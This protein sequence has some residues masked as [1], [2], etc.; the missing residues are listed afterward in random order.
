MKL[1]RFN[2]GRIG[3]V[4]GD[5][6]YDVTTMCGLDP[7][8]WPPVGMVQI[9]A[10]WDRLRPKLEAALKTQQPAALSSVKLQTPNPW[11]NKVMALPANFRDHV[12]EMRGRPYVIDANI[13]HESGFFLKA[14]SA[15]IGDGEPIELPTDKPGREFH[16]EC[17]MAIVIGKQCRHVPIDEALDV[18][19]G[20]ACLIDVTMRGL[21]ERV[22]RKSFETFCP[23]GP[24]IATADEVGS[25][26]DLNMRLWV[27]GTLRQHST[28]KSMIVGI[29]Q[30][31]AMCSY[32]TTLY[33]GDMIATGTMSG[34]GPLKPGDEVVIEIDRI[35]KMTLPVVSAPYVAKTGA[36]AA[37]SM[38]ETTSRGRDT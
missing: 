8:A 25:P 17:E 4:D 26:F 16:H 10:A 31:I 5:R 38:S 1:A 11:P 3:V 34:V 36:S 29:T 12:D 20:Y 22:M 24:W 7:A 21:E 32:V 35:G 37:V 28:P 2:G 23:V 14:S 18:V 13:K 33:P 30:A 27:N 19:F 9:I 15:M 6:I